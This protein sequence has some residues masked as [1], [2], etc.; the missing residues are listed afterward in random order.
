MPTLAITLFAALTVVTL[1]ALAAVVVVIV[2]RVHGTVQHVLRLRDEVLPAVEA[3]REDVEQA[4]AR[5][6][7]LSAD[8]QGRSQPRR[9]R[10]PEGDGELDVG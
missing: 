7:A 4:Q 9:A 1:V 6:A 5:A 2:D 8:R 3:L 10:L